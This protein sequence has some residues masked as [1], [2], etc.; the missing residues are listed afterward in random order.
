MWQTCWHV[1]VG[2]SQEQGYSHF[3]HWRS[4]ITIIAP[5]YEVIIAL[6]DGVIL[7]RKHPLQKSFYV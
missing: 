4:H 3:I 5:T 1:G 2:H 7:G 6:I